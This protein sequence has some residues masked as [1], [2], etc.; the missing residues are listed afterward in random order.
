MTRILLSEQ[1]K[2]KIHIL[3]GKL[4][5]KII[6][7]IHLINII[8]SIITCL[9]DYKRVLLKYIDADQLPV[10]YGGTMVD[11]LDGGDC[12]GSLV[13]TLIYYL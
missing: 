11:P 10:H 6:F 5:Y 4:S 7:T 2:S 12:C 3:G 1:T 9:G 13:S 8:L